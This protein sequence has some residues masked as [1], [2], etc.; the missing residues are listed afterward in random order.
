MAVAVDASSRKVRGQPIPVH[1]PVN[2]I[3]GNNGNSDVFVSAGGAMI[4]A[5]GAELGELG[6]YDRDRSFHPLV[7]E[8]RGFY[9]PRLSPDGKK[10]AVIIN[11]GTQADLWLYDI[12]TATLSRAT[13]MGSVACE[14]WMPDSKSI[15]VGSGRSQFFLVPSTGGAPPKL[16]AKLGDLSFCG[17]PS[18]DGR[19]IVA[20]S[21]VNNTW[22]LWTLPTDSTSA[23][24]PYV[25]SEATDWAARFS[26]D[27]HWIA[28]ESDLS[29]PSEVY[30]RS[31]PD[32][33]INVQVSAGGGHTPVWSR[34]QTRITYISGDAVVRAR[35]KG[36][37]SF[38]VLSRDTVMLGAG[39]FFL[40]TGAAVFDISP[41][42]N[43]ILAV[44]RERR[45]AHL[46]AVP[47]WIVEYR[48]RI[49]A[50]EKK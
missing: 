4:S 9:I 11:D 30:I 20:S 47:N 16:V 15:L 46:I 6:W 42:G 25:V 32:P 13:T 31:F 1:D 48:E 44:K 28:F 21:L 38:E 39:E 45:G 34:D 37:P 27:G 26:P 17:T 23:P 10:V 3:A 8:S 19:T 22:D 24:K 35:T 50:A 2:V 36:P 7:R 29:G 5:R 18:P 33:S 40:A 49:A 41:D 43:R 14:E 12:A